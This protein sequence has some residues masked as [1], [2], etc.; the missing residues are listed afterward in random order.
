MVWVQAVCKGAD[1]IV[2]K[3]LILLQELV[4][5][6][7]ADVPGPMLRQGMTLTG[8]T[9]PVPQL[10]EPLDLIVI[11]RWETVEV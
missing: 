4:T 6:R 11:I 3:E 9:V 2:V 8:R 7:K 5:L 1:G 10:Q